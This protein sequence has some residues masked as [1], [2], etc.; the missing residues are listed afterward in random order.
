MQKSSLRTYSS[1]I[2]L[3]KETWVRNAIPILSEKTCFLIHPESPSP[4]AYFARCFTC[5]ATTVVKNNISLASTK[6]FQSLWGLVQFIV[7][8]KTDRSHQSLSLS[9]CALHLALISWPLS[10]FSLGVVKTWPTV[11]C[12]RA[13]FLHTHTQFFSVLPFTSLTRTRPEFNSVWPS[14]YKHFVFT[15]PGPYCVYPFT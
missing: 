8:N 7:D 4:S 9:L 5:I 3:L 1:I 13:L 14:C 10:L 2:K 11:V 6:P 15:T 12:G